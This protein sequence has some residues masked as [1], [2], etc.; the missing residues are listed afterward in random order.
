MQLIKGGS[1]IHFMVLI[2]TRRV[3]FNLVTQIRSRCEHAN[4][5]NTTFSNKE[6]AKSFVELRNHSA[7]LS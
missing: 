2:F 7:R 1:L 6:V 3:A 4:S 5:A